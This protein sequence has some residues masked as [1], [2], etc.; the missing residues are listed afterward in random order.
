MKFLDKIAN[1]IYEH[2]LPLQDLVVV[3][4]SERMKK[5]LTSALFQQYGRPIISP[6]IITID[7]WVKGH[8]DKTVIDRTRAIIELFRIQLKD[9][10]SEE[11]RSFDEFLSWG[12]I[13]LND[14]NEIDRYLLDAE[15]I[16]RN[17]E[18][19]K[20]I[21]NWSFGN[22]ELSEGQK[23]FMEFWEKLPGFYRELNASL[24]SKNICY[25]GRAFR[26]AAE[27]ISRFFRANENASFVFAGFNALSR[28]EQSIIKQ[29]DQM[30][31]AHVLIDADVYYLNDSNHEAGRFIRDLIK[32]LD[33][34]KLDFT[35]DTLCN[36]ELNID[37]VECAQNTGQVKVAATKLAS[38]SPKELDATLL[39]LADES[40]IISMM[41]NLPA[42]IGKANI[43]LG[44]PIRNTAIKTWVDLIFSIQENKARFS[45]DAIYHA[46]LQALLNHPF[47]QA[48]LNEEEKKKLQEEE[49]KSIRNNRIFVR[50]E[51]YC[52]GD[53]MTS[54][55]NYLTDRWTKGDRSDVVAGI[56]E[57]NKLIYNDLN[58]DFA[59]EKAI[60]ECFDDALIDLENL[61]AEGLPEMN[62]KSFR[63]LFNQHWHT[64][65]IAYH[66]NPRKGLQIMGLLETRGL[67]FKRVICIG[68]NEGNLPSTNPVQTLIPMDLRKYH[69]LPSPREK[70]GLFAHHFYRLLHRCDELLVTYCT[71]EESIAT[72]EPSRYIL[73]LEKELCRR[74]PNITINRKVY[75]LEMK[76][77]EMH[78]SVPKTPE[79]MGRMDE[80]FRVSTSASMLKKYLECPL[81]F[82]F[83]YVMDFGEA[84]EIEEEVEHSTFGTFIHGTLEK[85]YDP[86]ARYNRDGT[87]RTPGPKNITSFDVEEMLKKYPHVLSE[88]FKAHFNND[89]HAFKSGKNLLS[90]K[91][92]GELIER[93]LKAEVEFLS[94]QTEDVFIESLERKYTAPIKLTVNGQEKEITLSGYVDRIDSIGDKIRII[95]YKTGKV[96]STDVQFLIRGDDRVKRSLF[97]R[98]HILQLVQYAYMYSSNENRLPEPSIISFISGGF[99]P[100]TLNTRGL[101]L[102]EIVEEFPSYLEELLQ[103]IYDDSIPFEH[104][105]QHYSYCKYC[106]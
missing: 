19:I 59:F 63:H 53:K 65:S 99:K 102:K 29:L 20:E 4:P 37:L 30:G 24:E 8:T 52:V 96:N 86:F 39:L 13:L 34:K 104:Q 83:R 100:F 3:V 56:R 14:F 79:I 75:S 38:L 23:R 95:D 5:Y 84:D 85:L 89:S 69:G 9:A 70:Q 42:M 46:D 71:D 44:L 72:N 78:M 76:M 105:E 31:R 15:Q 11:D 49:L 16:F 61:I 73:Q 36:R 68:M 1:Y 47:V 43:T 92:A 77:Q 87:K 93:F 98:K 26:E 88:E 66:G 27:D 18:D 60:I 50:K 106:V 94:R 21:E 58:S 45:T 62:F 67:D 7:K 32:V 33:K 41:K 12:E 91:M 28:S 81:D 54:I 55:L 74:N 51:S 35:E 90:F 103:E 40:L 64:K 17:L 80:L 2:E 97:E 6:E 101:D 48:I 25:P 57:L 10:K 82:Y 22:E